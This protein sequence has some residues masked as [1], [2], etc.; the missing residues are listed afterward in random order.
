[1]VEVASD[2]NNQS[3]KISRIQQIRFTAGPRKT[4]QQQLLYSACALCGVRATTN[5]FKFFL[6]QSSSTDLE[7]SN[8]SCFEPP[9]LSARIHIRF[10]PCARA[11]GLARFWVEGSHV[12]QFRRPPNSPSAP[13][14]MT[15]FP[16]DTPFFFLALP[17]TPC[18][19]AGKPRSWTNPDL[20]I[21]ED[22]SSFNK[23]PASMSSSSSS[24]SSSP[25]ALK[26]RCTVRVH[27]VFYKATALSYS[28]E[29][30]ISTKYEKFRRRG[31]D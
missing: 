2:L 16:L 21:G 20:R 23:H 4:I 13:C 17:R 10:T 26:K 22:I 31:L 3:A 9:N 1:M 30:E 12:H 25:P 5:V 24:L 14:F 19:A 6:Y 18:S 28:L 29:Y 7:D 15:L 11:M 8:K 27:S